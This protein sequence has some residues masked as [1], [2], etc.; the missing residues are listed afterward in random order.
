MDPELAALE[1]EF[2]SLQSALNEPTQQASMQS[3]VT[4]P[5]AQEVVDQAPWYTPLGVE[6]LKRQVQ[7]DVPV[8]LAKALAGTA[9]IVAYPAVKALQY[10]GAPVE[11]FGTSEA[12][13]G[14][15]EYLAPKL[16]VQAETPTQEVVSF[17]APSPLSKAKLTTQVGQGL[18]SYLGYKGGQLAA[19]ESTV[20]PLAGAL[21]APAV[22][23]GISKAGQGIQKLGS[24]LSI[25]PP[26]L[27]E[28]TN[29]LVQSVDSNVA[30]LSPST[31]EHPS[32][33][34]VSTGTQQVNNIITA[35]KDLKAAVKAAFED[36]EVYNAN[37]PTTGLRNDVNTIVSDWSGGRKTEVGDS[38]LKDAIGKLLK[39]EKPKL[40][41]AL[42][43]FTTETPNEVPLGELHKLQIQIGASLG[44]GDT[45]TPDEALAAK[46]Y[47]YIG[48]LIDNTP[49]GEKL[50]A[51]KQLSKAFRDAFV[52]DPTTKTKAPL[53]SA[54]RKESEKVVSFLTGGSSRFNALQKAGVDITPI[55]EQLVN[56]FNA[57]KTPQ[58]KLDW[59]N[60]NRPVL[61]NAPFWNIFEDAGTKLETQL[62]KV[63]P[64]V[65][66]PTQLGQ[67]LGQVA[68]S[69]LSSTSGLSPLSLAIALGQRYGKEAVGGVLEK[70]GGLVGSLPQG[71][72]AQALQRAGVA[73][74]D[75]QAP[76]AVK[77][78]SVPTQDAET[79]ALEAELQALKE[80]MPKEEVKV[81]KQN[82]SLPIGEEFAPPSLVKAVM[83]VESGGK[84]DAV[85]PKG[86][87]GPMQLMPGTAKQLGVDINDPQ[88]NIHGGSRYL[89]QMINKYGK[90]DIA[91]AAY[92]WGP[93]NIDKAIRQLKADGK[94]VT[95]SNIMQAV[96]VPMETRLYVNKVLSKEQQA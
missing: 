92:N 60:K 55:T 5:T 90:K 17:L 68:L 35:K 29:A 67:L 11:T 86:A 69:K 61:E 46:L 19:P 25:S 16:N 43:A 6:R 59:I 57:L 20:A 56:E 18:A 83:Q 81:G 54:Q 7:F 15:A 47:D 91:L 42:A 41:Q 40:G 45:F 10:A 96:K 33:T 62:G 1:A 31:I 21:L 14:L 13:K 37:V 34:V 36:P 84:T 9:D 22:V 53:A 3:G 93:G 64:L 79:A 24:R 65:N 27:Q 12:V 2:A 50:V 8:G 63:E 52:W 39:L 66:Q 85:S 49:G 44:K 88:E 73:V 75:T 89:Q 4:A 58:A 71:D 82:I 28:E 51:A 38:N 70:A 48:N 32:R 74:G 26:T 30:K 23:S 77:P 78:S 76:V 72:V 87:R 95:W 94:R 80:Q